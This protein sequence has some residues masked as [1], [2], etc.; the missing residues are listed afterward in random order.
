[1]KKLTLGEIKKETSHTFA[2]LTCV[3][4]ERIMIEYRLRAKIVPFFFLN[5]PYA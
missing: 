3:T 5:P 1:M 4:D 2:S